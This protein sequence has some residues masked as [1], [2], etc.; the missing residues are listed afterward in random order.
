M[1]VIKDVAK[2]AG[3]SVGTVSKY[4]NTPELLR[5]DKR[6]AVEDAIQKLNYKPNLFARN[7][8]VQDSRTIAV[9]AQEIRNPFHA[10]LFNTI[11]KEAMKHDYSVVLY[12]ISD[13]NG[14]IDTLFESLPVHYFSGLI[15]CYFHD[16]E[17]SIN[18]AKRHEKVPMVIMSN[19]NRYFSKYDSNK[20]VHTDFTRGIQKLCEYL[21]SL[22]NQNIAYIGCKTKDAA[23]EPKLNGFLMTMEKHHLKPHS[24]IRLEKEY[25]METGYESAEQIL[26]SGT[27]PD[28]ILSDTDVMAIGALNCLRDHGVKVPEDMMLASFD[29]IEFSRYCNPR[30]TTISVPI[31]NMS[32]KAVELLISQMENKEYSCKDNGFDLELIVRESTKQLLESV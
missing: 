21:I 13:V 16:M 22:G 1:A 11:R 10:A 24:I 5:E 6:A 29:N 15:L 27:L 20:I 17:Q 19:S 26:K 9:I 14:N 8:R 2:L 4:L 28:A 31:E 23:H 3:V 32:I 30:L 18:F 7:L 12:S 25:T